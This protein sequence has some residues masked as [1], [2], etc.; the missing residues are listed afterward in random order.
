MTTLFKSIIGANDWAS[1]NYIKQSN[2]QLILLKDEINLM[3]DD[4]V[5]DIGSGIGRTAISLTGYLN[6]N[7]KYEGFDVVKKGV[8]WCNSKI[9]KDFPILN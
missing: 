8:D 9:S 4:S 6:S 7:S 5:L 3:P 2:H 1:R